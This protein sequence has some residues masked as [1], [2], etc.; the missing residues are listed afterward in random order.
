M[1]RNAGPRTRS[2]IYR[3]TDVPKRGHPRWTDQKVSFQF[4]RDIANAD[5]F[6]EGELDDDTE[7]GREGKRLRDHVAAAAE[8]LFAAQHR[9]FL[10]MV[11]IVGRQFRLLR[12]D[13]AGAI[14]T[15]PVDYVEHSALL[16]DCL[17]RFSLLDD[18]SLGFDPTATRLRPRDTDFLHMDAIALENHS[19]VDHTERRIEEGDIGDTSVFR[20]V[21]S[22]FRDSLSAD[23]PRYRL[24]IQDRDGTRN[25]LVGKPLHLPSGVVGRGTRG[26]VALDCKTQRFVWLKDAW[27]ACDLAPEKEGEILGKLNLACVVNVPTLV[28]HGDV[29]DQATVTS[30]WWDITHGT[31]PGFSSRES[32]P[33]DGRK[34][35][36]DEPT[37]ENL[38]SD[39]IEQGAPATGREP[40]PLRRHAHY[41][42][43]VEEVAISLS[44]FRCG[45]Q[46]ASIFLDCLHGVLCFRPTL[47]AF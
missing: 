47:T 34:R 21:R 30:R 37:R 13:R 1:M 20:Y 23:W 8:L 41:R 15:P 46:L 12:W 7:A 27:R 14:V 17:R 42:I 2:A 29:E 35:K 16:C 28:C 11:L 31:R 6:E 44:E 26:Y 22:L 45:K 38:R 25:F 24:R 40:C 10:F 3:L 43:A 4:S 18:V 39:A 32:T 9:V 36:R 5:P 19:D 33:P